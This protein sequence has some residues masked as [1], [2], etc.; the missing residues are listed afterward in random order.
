MEL[1]KLNKIPTA[2]WTGTSSEFLKD[3][4]NYLFSK[5]GCNSVWEDGNVSL[6]SGWNGKNYRE[7]FAFLNDQDLQ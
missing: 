2:G 3:F 1:N 7:L 5:D 4:L 6:F